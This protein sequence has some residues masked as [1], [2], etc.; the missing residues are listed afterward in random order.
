MSELTSNPTP[1]EGLK[2]I[3][4]FLRAYEEENGKPPS[5]EGERF[6]TIVLSEFE[7]DM[8]LVFELVDDRVI[9]KAV[10]DEI[11]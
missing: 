3:T 8:N 9:I 2:F 5:V 6:N 1:D 11:E 7:D 4:F 10:V